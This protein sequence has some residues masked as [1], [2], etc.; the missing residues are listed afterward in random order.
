MQTAAGFPSYATD[1]TMDLV[2]QGKGF[3]GGAQQ[4]AVAAEYGHVQLINPAGSSKRVVVVGALWSVAGNGVL[5]FR[6]YDTALTTDTGQA[7]NLLRGGGAATAQVRTASN[8][9]ELGTLAWAIRTTTG[10]IGIT[11]SGWYLELGAGQG[12]LFNH[13]TVNIALQAMFTWLEL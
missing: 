13:D 10:A 9:A 11:P 6:E 2:R 7:R 5:R 4:A 8:A 1:W 3:H 12:V